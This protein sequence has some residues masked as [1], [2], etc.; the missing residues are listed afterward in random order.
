M[1]RRYALS[2]GPLAAL[3]VAA[4][5]YARRRQSPARRNWSPPCGRDVQT[6][7][8]AARVKGTEGAPIVL[9]HGLVASGLYWGSAYD[10]L[11][12]NHRLVVPDLLG[13][14]RSPRPPSGYGPDDHVRALLACLDELNIVE[15]VT[16]GAH[17]LGTLIALRLAATHPERVASIVGFGPPLY[18]DRPTALARVGRT[19]PMGRLFVLPG[20]TAERACRWVCDHRAIAGRLA[21][22]THPGLPPPIAADGVQHTWESYSETLERVILAADAFSWLAEVTHPVRFI[23]GD[24]DRVVDVAFLRLLE[25]EYTNLSIELWPGGHDLP[26]AFPLDCRQAIGEATDTKVV[27]AHLEGVHPHDRE[28]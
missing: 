9:L 16:I 24:R 20:Q 2:T 6:C 23:A 22:V 5:A 21:V 10:V 1:M 3:A 15:P 14:G 8:L 12:E 19:S 27:L 26:L 7:T 13:F 4:G 28:G 25:R 17:S 11:A 18:R